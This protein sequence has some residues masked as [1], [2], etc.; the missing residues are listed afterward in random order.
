MFEKLREIR[1]LSSLRAGN[2]F[3]FGG[4]YV[5]V[6]VRYIIILSST[7]LSPICDLQLHHLPALGALSPQSSP[8]WSPPSRN[9]MLPSGTATTSLTSPPDYEFLDGVFESSIPRA[10][11]R[12]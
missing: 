11:H 6:T 9:P 5:L 8:L 2:T 3:Y 12:A 7:W 4:D 1:I 10:L